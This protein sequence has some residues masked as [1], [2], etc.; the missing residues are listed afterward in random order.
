M[1]ETFIS[2]LLCLYRLLPLLA[3]TDLSLLSFHLLRLEN[4]YYLDFS[5]GQTW[6]AV[7]IVDF[8]I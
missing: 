7:N 1:L 6:C 8:E 4:I 2:T 3:V 5:G